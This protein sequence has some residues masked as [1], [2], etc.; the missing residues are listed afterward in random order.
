ML[1]SILVFYNL[2]Y[3]VECVRCYLIP[4]GFRMTFDA[5]FHETPS[6]SLGQSTLNKIKSI[7]SW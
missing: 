1:I 2:S 6:T 7:N 5:K 3:R 4:A